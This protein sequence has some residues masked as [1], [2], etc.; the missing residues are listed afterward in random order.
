MRMV[1]LCKTNIPG[2]QKV[3]FHTGKTSKSC[4][5]IVSGN[6]EQQGD[7]GATAENHFSAQQNSSR[8]P[9]KI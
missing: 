2:T 9:M 4:V 7:S 3:Q 8:E 1:N 6:R 5:E